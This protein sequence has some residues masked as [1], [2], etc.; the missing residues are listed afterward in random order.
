MATSLVAELAEKLSSATN[1]LDFDEQTLFLNTSADTVGIGTNSPASKLDVRGTVQ[2]G[3]DDTGY[4]VKFFGDTAS[5]Y[6]LWD[7]SA[8]GTVLVGTST[9]TGNAQLTGTLTVGVDDTGHDVKF[10]GATATNGYM[11]WDESTDD[12]ILGSASKIGIGTTAPATA[13]HINSAAAAPL[14]LEI[15]DLGGDITL[16]STASTPADGSTI[17]A[18]RWEAKDDGGNNTVYGILQCAVES[19]AGGSEKGGLNVVLANA[20]G[21]TAEVMTIMGDGKV[22]IGTAAPTFAV[23]NEGALE[24]EAVGDQFP[25]VRIERSGG[26]SYTNRA[27]ELL[28]NNTGDL[29]F[30]DATATAS[31]MIILDSGQ[32]GIGTTNPDTAAGLTIKQPA[33]G[34]GVRCIGHDNTYAAYFGVGTSGYATVNALGDRGIILDADSVIICKT[35]DNERVRINASGY[36]GI[37]SSSPGHHLDVAGT[38]R[39][40]NNANATVMSINNSDT[41]NNSGV[42]N[43]VF[44][45]ERLRF[46]VDAA[47]GRNGII[48]S[49]GGTTGIAFLTHNGSA[50]ARRGLFHPTNADFYTEDG[51]VSSLSD[52]RIKKDIEDLEDGLDVVNQ[53]RP[54]T[55]R[56]NGAG[57]MG[58]PSGDPEDVTRFGFIADEVLAVASQYV[59]IDPGHLNGEKIEDMKSLKLTLMIPMLVNAIKE[60][61]AEV[62]A[63]KNA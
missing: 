20:A 52:V 54:R 17:M 60:L 47:D 51:T 11:L 31:R 14:T 24:L 32:V 56:F 30:Y 29:N 55:F 39:F 45:S 48:S 15:T 63:L 19:D 13:L 8:D 36:V 2:V 35:D 57:D 26:S 49:N 6:W 10:F 58:D 18:L 53:L 43:H 16:K 59:S 12:L 40:V 21:S 34:G 38:A 41:T 44:S 27:Y 4:D 46:G 62:T 25:G 22:G 9:Q 28:L 33:L 5:K 23:L 50:W 37:G 1:N 3:V 7:T 42:M 61:S